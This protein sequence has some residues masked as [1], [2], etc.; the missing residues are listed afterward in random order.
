[1]I[2]EIKLSIKLVAPDIRDITID[3]TTDGVDFPTVNETVWLLQ[4]AIEI[5]KEN[6]QVNPHRVKG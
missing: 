2:T 1:M 4:N 5:I 3:T 6:A